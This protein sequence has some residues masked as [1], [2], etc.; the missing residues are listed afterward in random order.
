MAMRYPAY[1]KNYHAR[2]T[3]NDA[4]GRQEVLRRDN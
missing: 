3:V 1:L 2:V 4:T